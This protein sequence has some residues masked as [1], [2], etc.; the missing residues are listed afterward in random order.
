MCD[1][2]RTLK[3]YVHR[4]AQLT[5]INRGRSFGTNWLPGVLPTSQNHTWPCRARVDVEPDALSSV[6]SLFVFD[7]RR[8][9]ASFPVV[10]DAYGNASKG[11]TDR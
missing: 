1:G 9:H 7:D 10:Y 11:L 4:G 5:V 2:Y 6:G 8:D 3:F